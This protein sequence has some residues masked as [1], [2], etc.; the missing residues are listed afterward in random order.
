METN[1]NPN[2]NP[3]PVPTPP[4]TPPQGVANNNG[5]AILAY[6]GILIVIPF[7]T[8]AHK[9]PYVK[10]HLKQGLALIIMEIVAMFIIAIPILGWIASPILWLASL[11]FIIIGIMNAAS[12]K[13][14]ELPFIGQFARN[15]NF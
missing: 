13:M 8:E 5:M 1:T 10:F 9:D 6:L 11:V 12:G 2:T 4:P 15:F 3:N 7:L 14:K